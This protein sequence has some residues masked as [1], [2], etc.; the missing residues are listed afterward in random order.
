MLLVTFT[1][2]ISVGLGVAS[3]IYLNIARSAQYVMDA[4]FVLVQ[5]ALTKI[6][7]LLS[8]QELSIQHTSLSEEKNFLNQCLKLSK[9]TFLKDNCRFLSTFALI[10]K[11][12][13]QLLQELVISIQTN[14]HNN[15][16]LQYYL[17]ILWAKNNLLAFAGTHYNNAVENYSYRCLNPVMKIFATLFGF[18]KIQ[19]VSLF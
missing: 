16:Q 10:E 9:K 4:W 15:N 3:K 6:H 1:L 19:T 2:I 18:P 13:F 7:I 11:N 5:L 14:N 12:T 17:E 8:L